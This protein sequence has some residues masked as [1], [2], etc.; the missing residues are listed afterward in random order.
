L[1]MHFFV[2]NDSGNSEHDIFVDGKLIRQ[3]NVYA[4]SGKNPWADDDI[5]VLKNLKSI[6]DNLVVSIISGPVPTGTYLIGSYALKTQGENVTNFQVKGNQSKADQSVIYLNTLA[7]IAARAVE[8]ANEAGKLDKDLLVKVDMACALPVSQHKPQHVQTL[9]KGFMEGSHKLTVHLGLT[10]SVDV[11]IEF[12]FV[13]VLPEGTPAVFAL[14]LDSEGNWRTKGYESSLGDKEMFDEFAATYGYTQI[15]G[16]Y[17]DGKNIFHV[18]CGDGTTDTPFTLSDAVDRDLSAGVNHGVG[19]AIDASVPDFLGL[20]PAAGNS[21]SRQQFSDILKSQ[22]SKRRDKF[23]NEALQVFRP[24]CNNQV[25]PIISHINKQIAQIGANKIDI[26]AV[27]GGGSI[28]M[29][30]S[31][32]PK[33][34]ELAKNSRFELLYIPAEYAVTLNAEGLDYFVRSDLYKGVKKAVTEAAAAKTSV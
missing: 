2:G 28:L 27:Y 15:D 11:K 25:S 4:L 13:H 10:K 9:K 16:S 18:D 19:H 23:L 31:L 12:D 29:R 3:P 33:L 22:F 32:E 6:Y 1:K 20:V 7:M 26:L 8:K 30:D 17:L 24:H 5:D 34:K 14:Q 21:F